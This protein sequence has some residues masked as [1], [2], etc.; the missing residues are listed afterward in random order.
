MTARRS[1]SPL[2]KLALCVALSSPMSLVATAHAHPLDESTARVTL[3]DAHLEVVI[4]CDLFLMVS[5]TPTEVATSTEDS[6]REV[7]ARLRRELEAGTSL[8]V[9]G[10]LAPLSVTGFIEPAELRAMAA[11]LSASRETHGARARVRLESSRVYDNPRSVTL[12][13]PT[14]LGPLVVTF[15]QPATRYA[16]PGRPASFDVLSTRSS[17]A[18]EE[19]PPTANTGASVRRPDPRDPRQWM[20]AIIA[21]AGTVALAT[22]RVWSERGT[23]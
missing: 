20:A 22:R 10:S 6:L 23:T 16:W 7:H 17:V 14:S 21:L 4:D 5:S 2:A 12:S 15:T 11:T 1:P 13:G 9:D 18:R 3:R 19:P 8:R